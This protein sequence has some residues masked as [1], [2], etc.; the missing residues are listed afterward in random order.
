MGFSRQEYWSGMPLPSPRKGLG[1]RDQ[2]ANIH[3]IIV[4]AREFQK[5]IYFCF[6]DY[7]KAFDCVDHNKPW[8]ILKE[9]GIPDHFTCLL[10]NLFAGQEATVRTGRESDWFQIGKG[11]C[12]GCILSPCLFNLYAEYIMRNAGLE[13]AQAGIKIARRNINNLRYADDTTLMAESKELKSL[14]MKVKEESEKVGLKLSIQKTKIMASGL[15]SSWQI[16]GETVETVADFIFWGSRITADGDCSHEI[17][18]C[19]LLGRKTM[20][21]LDSILKSRDITLPIKVC[22]VK[23]MVFPVVMYGWESRIIKKAECQRTDAF[24]LWC[25]RRLLRVPWTARR[26][27]QSILKEISPECSLEGLMLKL[28]LQNFGHLIWRA[29][30]FEKTLMLGKIRR[31]EEK[32]TTEDEMVGWHHRLNG[33]EF[34]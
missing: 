17:K 10:R 9:M 12:Q 18:R 16:N 11:V 23:A 30:W 25:W 8:K 1:T 29:D 26:S 22:L 34:K 19:L 21:N 5:N 6:I 7:A 4:K 2:I 20:T 31:Q 32:G 15:I 24:E 14:L 13:E 33:Y 27:N 3:W 28:K